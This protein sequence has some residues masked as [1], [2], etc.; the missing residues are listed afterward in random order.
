M[1]AVLLF[2]TVTGC[3]SEHYFINRTFGPDSSSA[4]YSINRLAAN[5]NTD[6]LLVMLSFSGGG[7]RAAALAYGVLEALADTRIVW[8]GANKRLLDEVD[9]ISSASGGSLTAVYY[10]LYRDQI[11]NTFESDVLAADMQ[12]SVISR[13][14]SPR[15]LWRQ[16]SPRFGR[17]DLLQEVLDEKVFHGKTYADLLRTRPMLF[18]NA[19]EMKSGERF[20]FTQDQFD[21][22]CSDLSAFP[23]SRAVAASMAAPL[24]FSPI[25]L[26]N[27][28]EACDWREEPLPL[29]SG[30][31]EQRY[32]HLLDGGLH[33][34]VGIKTALEIAEA[35]GGIIGM[36]KAAR[37]RGIKK[38]VFV[39]VN[40]QTIPELPEDASP[41]TPGLYRQAKALIDIP[42][43][44]HS[45]NNIQAL[46]STIA[47]WKA[48]IRDASSVQLAETY[49]RAA[50]FY[51]VE[52]NLRAAAKETQWSRLQDIGV[53]LR[54]A[55]EEISLLKSFARTQLNAHPEWKRLL[56]EIGAESAVPATGNPV[57]E[58]S[59][60]NHSPST[61]Q[62]MR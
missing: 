15:G 47:R 54:L 57:K 18:V 44:L 61:T 6:S 58:D 37:M 20:E 3:S 45:H 26:W 23:L 41:N 48:E 11:F 60:R 16:S 2:V 24:I 1:S 49:D 62:H 59:P 25:T 5:D 7:Y 21:L 38:R 27:H 29:Q 28:S 31:R 51:V 8:A 34:N 46:H 53:T 50:D 43:D 10:G 39:I 55:S 42:I 35:R 9:L 12:S 4:R 13:I 52:I 30:V 14:L 32:V 22:L 19:T 36:A 56:S 17:G 40:A 33:D